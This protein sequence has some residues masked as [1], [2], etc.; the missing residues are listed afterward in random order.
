MNFEWDEKKREHNV[1]KHGLDFV[2]ATEIWELPM[3]IAP[4]QRFEYGE[5]R[6]IAMGVLRGRVVICAY[7]QRGGKNCSGDFLSKSKPTRGESV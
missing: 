7:T 4:D 3:V 2:D 1:E 5:S 6:Y